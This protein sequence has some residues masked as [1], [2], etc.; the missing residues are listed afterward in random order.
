[1]LEL[2]M[3]MEKLKLSCEEKMR[4]QPHQGKGS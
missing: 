2:E 4:S 3:E 1:M